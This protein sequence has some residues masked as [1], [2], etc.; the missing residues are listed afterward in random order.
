MAKRRLK[1]SLRKD[2]ENFIKSAGLDT[3][4]DVPS[5]ETPLS[6]WKNEHAKI[7]TSIT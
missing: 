6:K 4:R 3:F 5:P 1:S 2:W 7:Y